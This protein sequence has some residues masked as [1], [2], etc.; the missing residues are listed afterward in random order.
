MA[1]G[2]SGSGG[3]SGSA[4]NTGI[5]MLGGGGS[6]Q[7]TGKTTINKKYFVTNFAQL[8]TAPK[9]D[10]YQ[11]TNISYVKINETAYEQSVTYEAMTDGSIS[12]TG[13]VVWLQSGVKGTFEM[14]CSFE[15]KP[16]ELHPRIDKL[17]VDF[18]GYFTPDGFAK[19]PPTYTPTS[20]GGLGSA[21]AIPNPMFGVTRW[22]EIT[23]TLRHTYYTTNVN[24]NIWDTAG[25]V[26]DKL[27]AGIPIPKGEK[28][29]DGKEI[30]RR[31]MMQAPA[32][33]RQGE[34]WQVVQEYVLLDSKGVA[35]G[36]YE[37]GTVP[38]AT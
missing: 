6:F 17:S 11:A 13:G 7:S 21:N 12:D 18:G 2:S 19:W 34:A 33:S 14:F 27:P 31:W 20:G 9:I 26:V 22:K 32:V 8:Q 29:K 37:K 35:D 25:R 3:G 1:R 24:P 36:M 4:Q 15:S 38:G 30:P 28:D 5:E 16:I 23:L 10:G